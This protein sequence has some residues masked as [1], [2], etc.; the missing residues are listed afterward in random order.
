V[1]TAP[2]DEFCVFVAA[3]GPALFRVA[4]VLTGA[5]HAAEDLLQSL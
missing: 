5:H 3:R 4:I 1:G 2:R